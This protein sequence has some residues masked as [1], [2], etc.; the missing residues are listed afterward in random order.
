VV[1]RD[2]GLAALFGS[3]DGERCGEV[4]VIHTRQN[5]LKQH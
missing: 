5:V 2:L 1:G 3:E 4:G